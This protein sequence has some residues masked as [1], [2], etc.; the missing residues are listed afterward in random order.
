PL[1][2]TDKERSRGIPSAVPHD[3]DRN[4]VLPG[5]MLMRNPCGT[6]CGTFCGTSS[7]RV[8]QRVPQPPAA[9]A[10]CRSALLSTTKPGRRPAVD[11]LALALAQRAARV[12]HPRR[13]GVLDAGTP[14]L[15]PAPDTTKPRRCP[16]GAPL[17]RLSQSTAP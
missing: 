3:S 9:C 10:A 5:K 16:A 14:L 4:P 11:H 17:A 12:C 8:P 13:A 15:A 2:P 7:A 6:W 1:L